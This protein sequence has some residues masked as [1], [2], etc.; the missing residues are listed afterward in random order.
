VRVTSDVGPFSITP[1][2]VLDAEIS[3]RA[4]RLYGLLGRYADANGSS[5]ARRR[6]LAERLRCSVNSLDRAIAE[7]KAIGALTTDERHRDDGSQSSNLVTLRMTPPVGTPLPTGGDPPLP[8]GA[9]PM[10]ES[11]LERKN[12]LA[13]APRERPR[14]E[15]WDALEVIFGPAETRTAQTLRGKVVSSLALAGA[16]PAEINARARRWRLHFEGATMTELALEKHW[17]TLPRR[18]LK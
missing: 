18:P 5:F 6:T 14:N 10:N 1:E 3:D 13:A 7:L 8:T 2:W 12:T 15:L 16:T 9:A 17:D 4:V 11:H